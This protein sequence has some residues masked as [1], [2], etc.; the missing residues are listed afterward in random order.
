MPRQ[1]A[2]DLPANV[3][4]EAQDFFVSSANE[5]PYALLQ[6][7]STWPDHK[8]ALIGPAGSGKTHLARVFAEQ[9]G[10]T[11]LNAR[12]ITADTPMPTGPLVVEDGDALPTDSEEWLFHAHNALRRDAHA[13]LLTGKTPPSRWGI[14]LPDLA[15][16][17][18]AATRITIEN[19]DDAL[20]TAVLLKHFADRQLA[21]TPDAVAYLIKHLPRAFDAVRNIVE[22][23][24]R[25]ALA[26]SKPLSRPFV[27]TVLDTM[28]LDEG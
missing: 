28:H 10:A 13:L 14:T 24:D 22:T 18:S 26:Q 4:L 7:P 20:L 17:L 9:T 15:S 1:L 12:N 3:R 23:L 27:R 5:M 11:I 8:L 16:R 2:F 25:E 19:P 6:T 21:P